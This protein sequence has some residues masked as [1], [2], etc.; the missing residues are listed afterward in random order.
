M[1]FWPVPDI[2]RENIYEIEPKMLTN[3]GVRFIM[4]DVDNTIAPYTV[5][6]ASRSLRDWAKKFAD[7]GLE[8]FIL[9]NNRGSRPEIFAGELGVDYI[10][11]AW[12]PFTG[13]ARRIMEAKGY[14]PAETAVI[15]DQ[16]YT[17]VLCAK[18]LGAAA[19]L[20]H[21]ILF[22]NFLLRF[23]YWLE[24]PFRFIYKCRHKGRK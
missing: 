14:S 23:R 22:S 1:S 21:P 3:R 5:D 9:S 10:K 20:V 11:K 13:K 2:M 15:G 18:G 12:K 7:E 17:D 24:A 16:V 6:K 19:V 8:L 4:L